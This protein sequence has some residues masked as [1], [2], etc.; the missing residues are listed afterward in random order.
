MNKPIGYRHYRKTSFPSF[1]P[2]RH[3]LVIRPY[4]HYIGGPQRLPPKPIVF[5]LE[6]RTRNKYKE[7]K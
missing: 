2:A 5:V 7:E 4:A 6:G 1:P 3:K